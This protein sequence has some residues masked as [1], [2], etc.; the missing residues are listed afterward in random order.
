[1]LI[2]DK[3]PGEPYEIRGQQ[4]RSR[5]PKTMV[6]SARPL[7]QLFFDVTA[8]KAAAFCSTFSLLQ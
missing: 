5:P 2:R 4:E 1:M 3:R 7:S 8:E 6:C